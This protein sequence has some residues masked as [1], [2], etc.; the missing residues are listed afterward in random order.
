MIHEPVKRIT[1][2]VKTGTV[3]AT[4]GIIII[5]SLIMF[6]GWFAYEHYRDIGVI[7]PLFGESS[8]LASPI[9]IEKV[10]YQDVTHGVVTEI[11]SGE[12]EDKQED[13]Q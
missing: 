7:R 10:I 4:F 5:L 13:T 9:I 8:S 2:K 6:T 12:E 1:Q 3:S 11:E